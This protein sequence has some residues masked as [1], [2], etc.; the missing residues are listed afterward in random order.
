MQPHIIQL[1]IKKIAKQN[2]LWTIGLSIGLLLLNLFL[3]PQSI[4]ISASS[5]I[6]NVIFF[7]VLY[8][9]LIILHE[10][11]HLLG[12][13]LFGKTP[14]RSLSYGVDFEKGMAYATTSQPLPNYAMKKALLLP[15]WVTGVIP[16]F[17]GFW[18]NNNTVIL[19][20]AFLIAGAVGDIAMY[21]ELRKFSKHAKVQDDPKEPKL[22]VYD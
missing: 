4:H 17:I 14:F 5:I 1:D 19:V 3:Q 22:Y 20:G 12:F 2:I 10:A 18:L 7:V 15:F 13:V 16:T 6:W 8:V 9:V 11:C 21:K